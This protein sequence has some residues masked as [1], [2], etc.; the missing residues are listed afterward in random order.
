MNLIART[1][2][3]GKDGSMHQAWDIVGHELIMTMD[4]KPSSD[5]P[6]LYGMYRIEHY[7]ERIKNNAFIQV[8]LPNSHP[9]KN[10]EFKETE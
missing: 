5:L 2:V 10:K 6:L 3:V 8:N 7:L 1:L 4:I 9:D